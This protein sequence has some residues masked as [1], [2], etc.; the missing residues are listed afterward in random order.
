MSIHTTPSVADRS[1][2]RPIIPGRVV[3]DRWVTPDDAQR[4]LLPAMITAAG[5]DLARTSL[6]TV[7]TVLWDDGTSQLAIHLGRSRLTIIDGCLEITLMVEC[8]QTGVA[9][10]TTSFVSAPADRTAGMVWVT[11][12]LPTGPEPIVLTWHEALTALCW[13]AVTELT[14]SVAAELGTDTVGRRLTVATTAITADGLRVTP[15]AAHRFLRA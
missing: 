10:V 12:D 4:R 6:K 5:L 13:R 14:A 2:K 7:P 8:D 3:D 11:E 9:E 1:I 15:M